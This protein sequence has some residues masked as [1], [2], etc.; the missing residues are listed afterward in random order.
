[1]RELA[2][3]RRRDGRTGGVEIP[4]LV[5]LQ[6]DLL[7]NKP[8]LEVRIDRDR[9]S[10]LGVSVRDV[11][12][13]PSRSYSAAGSTCPRSSSEGEIYDVIAQLE[14]PGPLQRRAAC[15]ASTRTASGGQ[16]VPMVSLV[17]V[18][19]VHG[20]ARAAP[21]RPSARGDRGGE[22]GRG[23]LRAR[24]RCWIRSGPLAR[25]GAARRGADTGPAFSGESEDFYESGNAILFAY[26]LAVL[27]IFLVLSAQFESFLHPV[28]DPDRGGA[29]V[30]GRARR[31]DAVTGATLNLFSQIGLVML[32]GL[33][34]KNSILIVEFANQLRDRG[35][36][37][38]EAA[39]EASKTRF[40]PI[41]MTAI[42]TIVGILPIALGLG[43]G[44]ESRAPLGIA[45]VG[46]MFFSTALTVFV[47]PAAYVLV[48]GAR[49]RLGGRARAPQPAPATDDASP[50]AT[51]AG[52]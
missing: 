35:F 1:M 27:I 43:A 38:V 20:A 45:V 49:E 32:V 41:L 37:V 42:S 26:G 24:L 22:L 48:D 8:Q 30:H 28:H 52:R 6:T 14:S 29:L 19:R 23:R 25:R 40:R 10:D 7:L 11:A 50:V 12:S 31:P 13:A 47:V 16:L 17:N 2:R 33:V 15:S 39:F 34:T 4:G 3:L 5:N 18:A 46:G 44:G 51:S 36:G 21:L 9:A